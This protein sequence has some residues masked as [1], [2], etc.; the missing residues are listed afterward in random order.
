[1]EGLEKY[2][3]VNEQTTPDDLSV[4]VAWHCRPQ[5]SR[6]CLPHSPQPTA[7][8]P[9]STAHG[10]RDSPLQSMGGI[11]CIS[12]SC[13]WL[14][15]VIGGY[16]VMMIISRCVTCI[17]RDAEV[18]TL[19]SFRGNLYLHLVADAADVSVSRPRAPP[20][21]TRSMPKPSRLASK[22]TDGKQSPPLMNTRNTR[23]VTSALPA[24]WVLGIRNLKVIGE[25]GIGKIRK[26]GG[27]SFVS[28]VFYGIGGKRVDRSPDSKRSAPPMDIRNT[29]RVTAV[30]SLA[31]LN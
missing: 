31:T 5:T 19:Y 20:A 12:M 11:D 7:H 25:S 29:R 28:A 13:V 16:C 8:S 3:P 26:R 30:Y 27:R 6:V 15:S 17:C 21:A 4:Q 18:E 10:Q 1:M 22:R 14:S 23:G 9:Q 2:N 24:F